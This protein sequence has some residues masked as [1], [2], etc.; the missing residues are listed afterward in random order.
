MADRYRYTGG[1]HV[2]AD[3]T[4]VRQGEE[5]KPT[6]KELE[7]QGDLLEPVEGAGSFTGANIGLRALDMTDAALEL[8]LDRGL[9]ADEVKATEPSGANGDY[10]KSD[11][12]ALIGEE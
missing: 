4:T 5:F 10:L 12:Q 6:D 2:R 9:D 3:G 1:E 11:I 8:A 7:K